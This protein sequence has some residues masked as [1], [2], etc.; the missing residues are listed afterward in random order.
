MNCRLFFLLLLTPTVILVGMDALAQAVVY[1]YV[2]GN[3]RVTYSNQLMKGGVIV[4]LSPLTVLPKSQTAT[5]ARNPTASRETNAQTAIASESTQQ[6]QSRQSAEQESARESLPMESAAP[7]VAIVTSRPPQ[8]D[9][10][11]QGASPS[12]AG[13]NAAA[14]AKQRRE[15]VRR[16]I[17]EGEIDAESQLLSETQSDLQRERTKSSAMRSLRAVLL[18]DERPKLGKKSQSDDAAN[19]KMVV[20]RHFERV[21]ELQDQVSM[22]EENLAELRSQLRA[23]PANQTIRSAQLRPVATTQSTRPEPAK[24]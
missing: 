20:E 21:R 7:Q 16:R 9:T 19:T 10:L 8:A 24:R 18:A 11:R 22:H 3:G 23:Q 6:P 14:M 12:G 17:L 1:K 2:D 4:D 5:V 15:D 13:A